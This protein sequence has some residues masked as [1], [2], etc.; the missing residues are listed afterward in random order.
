MQ[1]L[2]EDYVFDTTLH[3]QPEAG[4]APDNDGFVKI[5]TGTNGTTSITVTGPM[6]VN[7]DNAGDVVIDNTGA[8]TAWVFQGNIVQENVGEGGEFSWVTDSETVAFTGSNDQAID[9]ADQTVGAVTVNKSGGTLT[10]GSNFGCLTLT[11]TA[12]TVD[13]N[14][15]TISTSDVTIA[16]VAVISGPLT[17]DGEEDQDLAIEAEMGPVT[18]NKAGGTVTLTKDLNCTELNLVAGTFDPNGKT[19]TETAV[20]PFMDDLMDT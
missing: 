10:F 16:A 7:I 9:L 1:L 14:G 8:S 2:A 13:F 20:R 18:I 12:G 5:D 11:I 4:T 3:L 15:V 19:I 17:L 6:R